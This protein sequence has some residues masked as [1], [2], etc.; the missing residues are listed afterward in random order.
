[1][2]REAACETL[3]PNLGPRPAANAL[4]KALAMARSGLSALGPPAADLVQA[5]REHI[6]I[7]PEAPLD[8]DFVDHE[9]ALRAALHMAPGRARDDALSLALAD[10]GVLLE[11]EPYADWALRP[12]ERLDELRL[13]ARLE[14]ARDRARGSGKSSLGAVTEAWEDCLSHDPTSEEA[15]S[16]LLRVYATQGNRHSAGHAYERCRAALEQLG[17]RPSPALDEVR[18]TALGPNAG[19]GPS[20]PGEPRSAPRG[21][22]W[23][24]LGEHRLVSAV[25]VELSGPVG[26]GARLDPEDL[27]DIVG[28]A[29]TAVIAEVEGLGGTVTSLSGGGLAALFGAPEAHEDDP[30]RAV[31]AGFRTLAA[32]GAPRGRSGEPSLS[33]RVGIE[34]GAAV[35]GPIAGTRDYG[36]VGE[37]VTTAAALQSAAKPWSVLVGPATRAATE[38]IFSWGPG[39]E[40]AVSPQAKPVT[41]SYLEVPKARTTAYRGQRKM[42][43]HAPLIGREAELGA[44]TDALREAISG[45]GS[46][47]FVVG[48][49]GLG[50]TRLVQECRQ[51]FMA[52]VGAGTGR[53]PLWLEGRSASYASST[54]YGL[55]QQLLAAWTG[56]APEEG[57]DLV[58][59]A[60]ERA[61]KAVF[62]GRSDLVAPLAHI[63]G[64]RPQPDEVYLTR[65][66]PE[67]L[68]RASFAAMRAVVARLVANGPTVLALEDLHWADPT[69]L[70]LT[71]EL[72]ALTRDGPLF[73]VA[74]R[75]PEPDPGATALESFLASDAGYQ[76]RRLELS[77]LSEQAERELAKSLIGDGAPDP[78]VDALCQ[79]V[80]GNPLFLEERL[81]SL[82][83]TGALVRGDGQWQL[84]EAGGTDVP[85]VLERLIR[86]RVDRL[87]PSPHEA[88]VAASVLGTQFPLS[89]LAAVSDLNGDLSGAVGELCASGLLVEMTQ[90]P[91]PGY[92][93]RHALIQEATYRG[94]VRARRRQL[95]ARAAWGL[96]SSSSDRLEEVAAQLGHHFVQA[97]DNERALHHLE[98]AGDHA[99]SALRQRRSHR[100][101]PLRPEH[102][103]PEHR[104]P[105]RGRSGH[106]RAGHGRTRPRRRRQP[107]VCGRAEG[108]VGRYLLARRAA[109]GSQGGSQ[110][111]ALESRPDRP[112]GGGPPAGP[113]GP[114]RDL[115]PSL[116]RRHRGLRRRRAPPRGPPRTPGP[117][118][119]RPVAGHP[120]GRAGQPLLLA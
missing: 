84:A 47:A 56:V 80:E 116:R 14:L 43:G 7:S 72:A 107:S 8:V 22:R 71:Q 65:L 64:L 87:S 53:L 78:V 38:E 51:R 117:G 91:E 112:P 39:E 105:E 19:R 98:V 92:R 114:D 63:M 86:A 3:F 73:V 23:H 36:A 68:Q 118:T 61:M 70:R 4:S 97:G 45:A 79:S 106:G 24:T 17:L 102:R 90:V 62:Q 57:D 48:E 6:W 59:K 111:G 31:R 27:R 93:F 10:E 82:L 42:A 11:D 104:R 26:L 96:E 29:L 52:W 34:T 77:P 99:A 18:A 49:P 15:A 16:A 2:G 89:A 32:L 113:P 100:L 85:E 25:F 28:T 30:E 12:R 95:H 60:L 40:V 9:T 67:G 35:V 5:D 66:S 74:T 13:R 46:L 75:R 119:S 54:P 103:R 76:L 33:V 21:P 83:E 94:L 20:T 120:A 81:S 110:R 41:A 108:Q 69:S 37:V 115:R 58:R 55:Y 88:I 1:M 101:V 44:L 109:R 50:K